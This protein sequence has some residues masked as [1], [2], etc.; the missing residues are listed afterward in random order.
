MAKNTD[1]IFSGLGFPDYC[2]RGVDVE[3]TPIGAAKQFRRDVNGTLRD[4]SDPVFRKYQVKISAN[5]QQFP[6]FGGIWPGSLVTVTTPMVWGSS[7]TGFTGATAPTGYG[8]TGTA[9]KVTGRVTE[10]NATMNEWSADKSWSV[11]IE[12][13]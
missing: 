12:E 6:D 4:V 9:V 1:I 7:A 3:V 13:Q 11:T 10:M 5:D 2:C 8:Y